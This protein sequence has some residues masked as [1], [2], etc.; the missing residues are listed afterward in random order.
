MYKRFISVIL[1]ALLCAALLPLGAQALD[2]RLYD[3]ADILSHWEEDSVLEQLD[4]VSQAYGVDIVVATVPNLGTYSADSYVE[5]FYDSNGIGTGSRKD[6]ALLLL[7]MA[8]RD[9]RILTNGMVGDAIGDA[10]IDSICDVIVSDLSDGNYA[11]AFIAFAEEC[12]Y[13]IDGH[14]NGFPFPVG[15]NL[16]ICLVVGLVVALIVTGIMRS[17]LKSV[18]KQTGAGDYTRA[19]SMQLTHRSDLFLYRTVSRVRIQSNNSSRGGGGGSRHVG[20]GKF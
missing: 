16:L 7:S 11:D 13:Y 8:E 12:A 19:G 15:Q 5:Y 9:Y 10:A 4:R 1:V 2:S 20:G 14:L 3:G 18:R 17:Q 6:G